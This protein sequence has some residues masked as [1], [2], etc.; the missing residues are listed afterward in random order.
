M[1]FPFWQKSLKIIF[2]FDLH[3]KQLTYNKYPKNSKETL[4]SVL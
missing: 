4:N 1:N 3:H 2:R